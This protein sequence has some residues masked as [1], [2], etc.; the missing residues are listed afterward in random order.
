MH[1]KVKNKEEII[2]RCTKWIVKNPEVERGKWRTVF[3]NEGDI[4][5][6]IG[7][8]KGQFITRLATQNPFKNFIAV[9]G[10]DKIFVRLLQ[11]AEQAELTNL[12]LLPEY[13]SKLDPIFAPGEIAG[14]Y[15]NFCDPWPKER[16]SKRRLTHRDMLR[17]YRLVA[18]E[19]A[20]LAFKTDNQS[21]FEFSMEEFSAAGLKT[22]V[23][24]RD[25]HRS[26][27]AGNNITTEYEDKFSQRGC[28]I[29][30]ILAEL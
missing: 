4:Y 10:G 26:I 21:L 18:K 6:E 17:Q 29:Y 23:T 9:E 27:Y 25:L 24:T 5:L 12:L 1:R 2:R 15:L 3:P 19:G 7:S 30:Y 16:H 14:I 22:V 13:M 11:K 20:L 8:G 28:P